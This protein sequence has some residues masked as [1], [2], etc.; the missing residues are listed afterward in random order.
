M[1][2]PAPALKCPSCG[3]PAVKMDGTPVDPVEGVPASA[4][5]FN[6]WLGR[7][8]NVQDCEKCGRKNVLCRMYLGGVRCD[9]CK[10]KEA[11][12]R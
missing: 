8:F 9:D 11:P 5:C 10:A 3:G 12:A 1:T 2:T 4:L 6:C 7:P